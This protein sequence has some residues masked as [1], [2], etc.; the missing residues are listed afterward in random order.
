MGLNPT[1]VFVRPS[2]SGEERAMHGAAGTAPSKVSG[3][4]THGGPGSTPAE[5]S[6]MGC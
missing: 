3:I 2:V 4:L 5:Y 6:S 1:A